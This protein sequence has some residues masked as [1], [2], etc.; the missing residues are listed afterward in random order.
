LAR[1]RFSSA[2]GVVRR[3]RIGRV[4][5]SEHLRCLR[6]R[7]RAAEQRDELA[8]SQLVELHSVPCQPDRRIPN[9]RGS[10]SGYQ[11]VCTTCQPL[12]RLIPSFA[13]VTPEICSMEPTARQDGPLAPPHCWLTNTRNAPTPIKTAIRIPT[14]SETT[15]CRL[16]LT[17][18]DPAQCTRSGSR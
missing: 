5:C 7:R 2:C 14:I 1:I 4:D 18:F 8:S 17:S 11:S 16:G 10:V 3:C 9:W 13:T 12:A 15:Q 6:T